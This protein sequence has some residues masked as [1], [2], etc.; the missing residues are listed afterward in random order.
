MLDSQNG[1]SFI[2]VAQEFCTSACMIWKAEVTLEAVYR[3]LALHMVPG[4]PVSSTLLERACYGLAIDR[5]Q[6]MMEQVPG[7]LFLL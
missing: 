7:S 5:L 3:N 2:T 6:T 1:L 4:T